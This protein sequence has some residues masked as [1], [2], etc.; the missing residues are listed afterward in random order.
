MSNSSENYQSITLN[1]HSETHINMS[2]DYK[3]LANYNSSSIVAEEIA[4]VAANFPIVLI[5]DD[6]TGR[7]QLSALYGLEQ[8]ENLFVDDN[9]EWLATYIPTG[10]NVMPFGLFLSEEDESDRIKIDENSAFISNGKGKKLFENG[11]PSAFYSSM[12]EQLHTIIDASAQTE[13]FIENLVNRNLITELTLVIDGLDD[14][15]QVINDLYTINTDE[16]SYLSQEDVMLFHE[17]HYWGPI[18][19]IQQSL[20]QFKKLVQ[21]KNKIDSN[22]NIKL[23]VHIE[24]N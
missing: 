14:K 5:K 18:Y 22:N 15:P 21:L 13:H 16:F 24:R 6:S 23:S 2:N 11:Q 19:A 8:D 17:L 10:L 3:H 12:Q 4:D 7:F 20:S 9:N 1:K